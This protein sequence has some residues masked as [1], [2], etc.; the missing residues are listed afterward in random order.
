MVEPGVIVDKGP[1]GVLIINRSYEIVYFNSQAS[2]ILKVAPDEA[3]GSSLSDLLFKDPKMVA[4][5]DTYI[6]RVFKSDVS[7]AMTDRVIKYKE[8]YLKIDLLCI[9]NT[10]VAY[11]NDVTEEQQQAVELQQS[12]AALALTV[13]DQIQLKSSDMRKTIINYLFGLIISLAM[14]LSIIHVINKDRIEVIEV[15]LAGL[16]GSLSSILGYYFKEVQEKQ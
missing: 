6:E 3:I 5:H 14:V 2:I 8:R 15:M 11:L 4:M 9:D 7:R 16:G 13:S 10:V 1:F 12:K